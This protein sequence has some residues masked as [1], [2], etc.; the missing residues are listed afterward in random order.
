MTIFFVIIILI[1]F[2]FL[3]YMFQKT[4]ERK[5]LAMALNFY[6]DSKYEEALKLFNEIRV[7]EKGNKLLDWYVGL[8]YEGLRNFDLALAEYNKVALSTKFPPPLQE[9]TVHEKIALLNLSIG[10]TK[11]AYQ[12]FL[13]VT[14]IAPD[15]FLAYY[16][17][18]IISRDKGELKKGVEFLEKAVNI[19]ADFP[20]ALVE[21]GKL[22]YQLNHFDRAKIVLVEAI[23]QDPNLAE[24]HFY[25]AL[26]LEHDKSYERSAEEFHYAMREERL[27]FESYS[28]LGSIYMA[29]GNKDTAFDFFEKALQMGTPDEKILLETKYRYAGYLVQTGDLNKALKLWKEIQAVQ[30]RYMDVDHKV[31]IYEDIS[32]SENLTRFITCRKRD[33]LNTGRELCELLSIKVDRH[34]SLKEDFVE[35]KGSSRVGRD[36]ISCLVHLVKWTTPVGEIPVRELLERMVEEGA[37]KGIFIT[38][39][40]FTEKAHDLA[41]T[42]PLELIQREKLEKLLASVY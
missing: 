36:E 29:M 17:L 39:S 41:K 19:K 33:F 2:S 18:G 38:P 40:N 21:L 26:M 32:R 31:R 22:H 1:V 24:A 10:N 23:S 15:N 13:I 20:Q 8:C 42:R 6:R 11:K 30:P 7:K 37:S 9:V 34:T 35:F 25:Y 16:Y 3:F 5:K 4:G 28:H 14:S 27:K 12:E